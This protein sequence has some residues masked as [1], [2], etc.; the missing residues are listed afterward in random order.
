MRETVREGRREEGRKRSYNLE[1]ERKFM[2]SR[3][4]TFFGGG[5]SNKKNSIDLASPGHKR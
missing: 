4:K 1:K 5:N 2:N 3:L